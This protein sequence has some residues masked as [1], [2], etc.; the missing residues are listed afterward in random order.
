MKIKIRRNDLF[1]EGTCVLCGET[2]PPDIIIST[3]Y[4]DDEQ[5][6]FGDV[7]P[8]CIHDGPEVASTAIHGQIKHL[9][10]RAERLLAVAADLEAEAGDSLDMPNWAEWRRAHLLTFLRQIEMADHDGVKAFRDELKRWPDDKL[11]TFLDEDVDPTTANDPFHQACYA[12]AWHEQ[13]RR[14]P[15]LTTE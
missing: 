1:M 12:V 9:R 6:S 7:C 15:G 10:E 14:G 13:E 11:A 4:S 5:K 3:A 8:K 2:F